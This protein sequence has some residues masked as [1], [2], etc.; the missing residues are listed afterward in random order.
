[1]QDFEMSS[2]FCKTMGICYGSG[3]DAQFNVDPRYPSN[4]VGVPSFNVVSLVCAT[5]LSL[6]VSLMLR[7]MLVGT[8]WSAHD[9]ATIEPIE[10]YK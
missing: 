5:L 10:R 7:M 4:F 1:M 3:F 6:L 9:I 2:S 8:N